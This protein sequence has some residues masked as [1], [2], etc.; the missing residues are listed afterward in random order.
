MGQSIIP[1]TNTAPNCCQKQVTRV[2]IVEPKPIVLSGK[3]ADEMVDMVLSPA[4]KMSPALQRAAEL[5]RKT[6]ISE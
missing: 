4:P 5:Y 3:A 2:V 6:V 1:E